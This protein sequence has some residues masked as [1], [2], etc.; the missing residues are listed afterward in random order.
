VYERSNVVGK[1]LNT[2]W[3]DENEISTLTKEGLERLPLDG[4]RV[5]VIVPDHTRTMPLPLFFRLLVDNLLPRVQVLN[6]LVAL[7]THPPMSEDAILNMFGITRG[8]KAT[9]YLNIGI[10]NHE[11]DNPAALTTLGTL[12]AEELSAISQGML[13][14]DVPVRLNRLILEHDHLLVCGPVFPHEVVGFSGGNKYFFPGIAGADIINLTHW[15]GALITSY[16]IIGHRDT[17]VRR[18][19]D[20]AA[21]LIPRPRHALCSV[22]DA[23]EENGKHEARLAGLF[24][25]SPEAAFSEAAELSARRHIIWCDHPYQRVLSVL[26]EMYDELWVGAKGMYKLEP[27]IADGGEVIIYAPHLAEI[28]VVHGQLIRQIG[29]HVRDYFLKQWEQFSGYPWSVLAHSTHLR[30]MGTYENGLERPRIQ[31]TLAT[32]IPKDVCRKVNLGYCDPASINLEDW[33][34]REDEGILLVPCAGEF[35]FRLKADAHA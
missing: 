19:I 13:R 4:K 28:S 33:A 2:G 6:F 10:Y 18:L 22:V 17:P 29:Y 23:V 1:G 31:V 14:Q 15:L 26:P 25:G 20:K 12:Q 7:G 3:L 16:K 35:L 9:R 8:E 11:W 27:V 21:T 34:G 24:I 30:G 32:G 5:L